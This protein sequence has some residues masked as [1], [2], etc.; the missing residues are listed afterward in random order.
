MKFTDKNYLLTKKIELGK[1]FGADD[2]AE[3]YIDFSELNTAE[4]FNL[5]K[6]DD[7]T[8]KI[9]DLLGSH[10]VSHNGYDE[11][12]DLISNDKIMQMVK[13]KSLAATKIMKE[14]S[15]W[16]ADPFR[17]EKENS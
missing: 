2:P 15:E 6:S 12:G 17:A 8:K 14:Y 16:I 5:Q 4:V 10:I 13:E 9:L 11:K 1:E 7:Q 3:F